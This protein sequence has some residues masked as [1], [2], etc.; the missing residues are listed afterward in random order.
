MDSGGP[1]DGGLHQLYHPAVFAHPSQLPARPHR[2]IRPNPF[3]AKAT[4]PRMKSFVVIHFRNLK[5]SIFR[6]FWRC[7]R[8]RLSHI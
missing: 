8:V 4:L 3:A 1:L 6:G 5:I 2:W 7:F